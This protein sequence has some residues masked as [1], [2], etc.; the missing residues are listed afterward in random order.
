[1]EN[2]MINGTHTVCFS[3]SFYNENQ[4]PISLR[5]NF[6]CETIR[7]A[8]ASGFNLAMNLLL[9]DFFLTDQMALSFNINIYIYIS[10]Q[11]L[12]KTWSF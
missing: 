12:T 1:M 7:S 3:I 11:D 10:L 5:T 8:C 9:F 6:H 4:K 2:L